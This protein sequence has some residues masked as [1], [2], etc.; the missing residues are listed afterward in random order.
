MSIFDD[1]REGLDE[2]AEETGQTLTFGDYTVPAVVGPLALADEFI[3]GLDLASNQL[4]G[5]VS[6][7]ALATAPALQSFCTYNGVTYRI[8]KISDSPV[9][10]LLTLTSPNS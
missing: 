1:A 6:K 7:S 3:P 9:S 4:A 10:W 5:R 2:L 8:E